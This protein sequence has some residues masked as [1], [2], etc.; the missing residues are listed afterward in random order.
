M[1]KFTRAAL[2]QLL[3]IRQYLRSFHDLHI[4]YSTPI[5]LY[6]GI[7]QLLSQTTLRPPDTAIQSLNSFHIPQKI[8]FGLF[9]TTKF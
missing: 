3:E 2:F 7:I 1:S 9:L 6:K 8:Y 5:S 4:G